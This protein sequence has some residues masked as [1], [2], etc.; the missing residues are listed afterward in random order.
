VLHQYISTDWYFNSEQ[1]TFT[2]L[3]AL[4]C[5]VWTGED[6]NGIDH[7]L[8]QVNV[9]C[10]YM[11]WLKKKQ[12]STWFVITVILVK[13]RTRPG[14][15]WRIFYDSRSSLLWC[16]SPCL[17]KA[18][19]FSRLLDHIQTHEHPAGLIWTDCQLSAETTTYVTH[20]NRNRR[21]SILSAEFEPAI[22]AIERLQTYALDR[23]P[24]DIG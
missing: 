5:E 18:P 19:S 21:T 13:T 3:I 22:P 12:R 1:F 15:I 16:Y 11:A 8:F 10:I 7:D 6:I 17:A 2:S 24:T 20:N 14:R 9:S 4:D 23:T